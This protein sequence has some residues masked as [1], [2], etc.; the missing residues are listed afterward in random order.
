MIGETT[1]HNP[2]KEKMKTLYVAPRDALGNRNVGTDRLVNMAGV[3]VVNFVVGDVY[4]G[5]KG[6]ITIRDDTYQT[7]NG[8]EIPTAR[9]A[10]ALVAGQLKKIG[11]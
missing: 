10:L 11:A 9:L 5:P 2:E 8:K 7:Y 3:D 6:T 1:T 4:E